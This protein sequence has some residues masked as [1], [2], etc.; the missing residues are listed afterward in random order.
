MFFTNLTNAQFNS[1]NFDI[2]QSRTFFVSFYGNDNNSGL[3]ES[4]AWQTLKKVS[5]FKFKS[6]DI[7]Q[8]RGGDLFN[9][10]L[11]FN[12]EEGTESEP[13]RITSY[14]SGKAV[15]QSLSNSAISILHKGGF[16]LDNIEFKGLYDPDKHY[17]K[18]YGDEYNGIMIFTYSKK[19]NPRITVK[20]CVIRNFRDNAISIGGDKKTKSG[21]SK[22]TLENNIIYDCGDI[23][24]K[25]WGLEYNKILITG[26]TIFNIKGVVPH[27]H[28]FSGNGISLS[29]I[30]SADVE[31]NLIYNNGKYA[32]RS[33]GGIVTGESR[34]IRVRY[35]EI[36]GIKS[37][38][39]DGDA[40]DFDNGSDSCI[41]EYNY[42]HQ[43]DGA[44]VLISGENKGSGSDNN[45]V[46]YNISKNDA[47]RNDLGAIKIYSISGADNNRIY[48]NT[49]ISTAIGKNS[50]SC[51]KIQGPTTN[52]FLENN[53]LITVNSAIFINIDDSKQTNLIVR[54]N[55]F[56]HKDGIFAIVWGNKVFKN[57][58][59]FVE[60][61]G[62]EFF[63]SKETG[64]LGN[65]Q[66]RNPFTKNDTINNAYK[67]DTLSSYKLFSFSPLINKGVKVQ[68]VFLEPEKDFY[69]SNLT[70]D[71]P[72]DIGAHEY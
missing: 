41:A 28:G 24:I 60:T 57:Y 27:S 23:G 13:I 8:F 55:S 56:F 62:Q 4:N 12:N 49:I 53:I 50:P 68:S 15:I 46:R 18:K 61:T 20:N 47:L 37:N 66:L 34:S 51:F 70:I 54:S 31:R 17:K 2:K 19:Q 64:I 9:G 3:S 11:L 14:G 29:H 52:T 1:N 67:I 43:N 42:T 5:S 32:E 35:N 16:V 44:G 63:N 36:Y 71:N 26:N 45:I 69:G 25:F 33:G 38:D 65:P 40:I 30:Y 21:Y 58:A 48:N 22:V 7:I 59:G 6:G 10:N 39:V 72:P